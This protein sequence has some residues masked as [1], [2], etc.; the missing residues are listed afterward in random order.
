MKNNNLPFDPGLHQGAHGFVYSLAEID[1]E[2]S[3]RSLLEQAPSTS[4]PPTRKAA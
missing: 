3:R 2:I 4:P 1:R